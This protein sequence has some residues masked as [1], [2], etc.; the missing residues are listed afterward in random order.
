MSVLMSSLQI[1]NIEEE[2]T[3]EDLQ[4]LELDIGFMRLM[5]DQFA[6]KK[7]GQH[8]LFLIRDFKLRDHYKIGY[9]GGNDYL[10]EKV[11]NNDVDKMHQEVRDHITEAFDEIDCC[12]LPYP[13]RSVVESKQ[14]EGKLGDIDFRF[15]KAAAAATEYI[16]G[17]DNLVVKKVNG[18]EM[19]CEKLFHHMATLVHSFNTLE[20]PTVVSPLRALADSEH[21][22]AVEAAAKLYVAK[23]EAAVCTTGF[24]DTDTL[25]RIHEE[26]LDGALKFFHS[27]PKLGQ[28]EVITPFHVTKLH[29]VVIKKYDEYVTQNSA[30]LMCVYEELPVWSIIL[31]CLVTVSEELKP[32]QE[33]KWLK[34]ILMARLFFWTITFYWRRF[35]E[36]R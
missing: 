18:R 10:R 22:A 3:E 19:T 7:P 11:F 26:S 33:T 36:V 12:T 15:K 32:M 25:D 35:F 2:I 14:F 24:T 21:D 23:M 29:N 20:I 8:L 6:D 16:L 1:Y 34:L 17:V 4:S 9:D 31:L 28:G 13:G 5:P 27:K 30:R